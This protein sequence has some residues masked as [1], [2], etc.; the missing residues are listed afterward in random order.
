[1]EKEIQELEKKS[2][3]NK[4][5][6]QTLQKNMEGVQLLPENV[7]AAEKEQQEKIGQL[8]RKNEELEDKVT[9][10]TSE[11]K[12]LLTQIIQQYVGE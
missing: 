10:R 4:R 7:E 6:N 9:N 5:E 11:L 12:E 8:Q 3:D 2:K 1:M